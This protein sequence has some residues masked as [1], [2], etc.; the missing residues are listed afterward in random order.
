MVA[1]VI[2]IVANLIFIPHFGII[3][4]S[5]ITY[6]S[7]LYQGYSGFLFKPYKEY[8]KVK[9]PFVQILLIQLAITCSALGLMSAA[10]WI[11]CTVSIAAIIIAIFVAFRTQ[12][13]E[14]LD[15]K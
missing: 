3:G 7:F 8:S 6:F 11:K 10:V 4:A 15:S 1:G 13:Y 12:K 5:V 14:M 9:Y 2:A